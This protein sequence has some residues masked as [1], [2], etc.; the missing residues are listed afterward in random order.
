MIGAG[1]EEDARLSHIRA[2]QTAIIQANRVM[3]GE[4]QK[5]KTGLVLAAAFGGLAAV[6]GAA[7]GIASWSSRRGFAGTRTRHSSKHDWR[8]APKTVFSLKAGGERPVV[9]AVVHPPGSHPPGTPLVPHVTALQLI[10]DTGHSRWFGVD[11]AKINS[12]L[13]MVAR[14]GFINPVNELA[15]SWKPCRKGCA[16]LAGGASTEHGIVIIPGSV[17]RDGKILVTFRYLST[18][19]KRTRLLTREQ[20]DA[21]IARNRGSGAEPT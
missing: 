7:Y 10:T 12:E 5:Q 15:K 4:A 9:R 20:L 14:G 8:Y 18:G 3:L 21:E 11:D 1:I 6:A 2:R 16:G 17:R 13:R 19:A